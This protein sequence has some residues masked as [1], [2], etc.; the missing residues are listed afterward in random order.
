MPICRLN[1]DD[2]DSTFGDQN[3][4]LILSFIIEY[5]GRKGNDGVLLSPT[6]TGHDA[7]KDKLVNNISSSE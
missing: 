3:F 7:V 4:V 5:R 1:A 2:N 6:K